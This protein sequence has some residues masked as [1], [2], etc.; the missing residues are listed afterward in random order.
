M[1]VKA[2]VIIARVHSVVENCTFGKNCEMVTLIER[3]QDQTTRA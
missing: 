3:E 2:T 1:G